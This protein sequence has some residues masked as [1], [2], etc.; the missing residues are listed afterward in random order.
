MPGGRNYLHNK[1][2]NWNNYCKRIL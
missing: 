1:W 2:I